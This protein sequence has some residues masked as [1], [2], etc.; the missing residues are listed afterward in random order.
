MKRNKA[1]HAT[2]YSFQAGERI[3][4]DANVW[5]F[6]QPPAAQPPPYFSKSY[7]AALKNL[8]AAGAQPVIEA[9]VLSEYLN[10][11]LRLEY[12]AV[13]RRGY[14]KF[15]DFRKSGDFGPLAQAA[16]ADARQI[17]KLALPQD[18]LLSH[19][20][21]PAVLGETETGTLDFNDGVLVETCRLRGWKLL[22][23]DGDMTIGGIEVLTTYPP[24]LRA[25]P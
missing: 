21:I 7:S 1:H 22:T 2:S 4:V 8:L 6:V 5:L 13:W 3:L 12:D 17:L 11:Y 25:C 19:A 9:L 23:N 16:V 24:L 20:N 14:P 10:R 18:T 15:K